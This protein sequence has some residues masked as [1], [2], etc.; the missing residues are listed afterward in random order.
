MLLLMR[1]PTT[2]NTNPPKRRS[3]SNSSSSRGASA[4]RSQRQGWTAVSSRGRVCSWIALVW[5]SK[6]SPKTQSVIAHIITRTFP[7][8]FVGV[9]V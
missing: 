3:S 5:V 1:V 4:S 2:T 6:A 8:S 7:P 9:C